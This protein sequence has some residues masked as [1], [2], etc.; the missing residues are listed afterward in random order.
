MAVGEDMDV[1]VEIGK[2]YNS[3]QRVTMRFG[4]YL[5]YLALC[6]ENDTIDSSRT[7]EVD[8]AYLAQNELFPQVQSD[9]PIPAFCC[10]PSGSYDV[11]EGKLY[12]TML[13]MGPRNT[14]SPL[15]FD[16]LD[17]LLIQLVGWKRILLFPPNGNSKASEEDHCESDDNLW[18]YAGVNG[19]QY[20]TSA[21]DIEN[22]NYD[23]HPNFKLAPV[24][25]EC[26]M[27]PGDVLYIPSKWWH[28]VRS[29]EF[30]VS[31]NIWWR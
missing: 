21:V 2:G 6:V 26:T 25:F 15:H 7:D 19:N 8:V 31:A 5:D 16:P 13:W 4:E 10:E 20:N 12:H 27:G 23:T 24:P 3:G 18:H 11:G 17:N 30:S 1:D 28:H 22:P 29:L 9:V 14:V